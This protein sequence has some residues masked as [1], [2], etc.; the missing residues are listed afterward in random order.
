MRAP[1][2]KAP[3]L[4]PS[5][6]NTSNDDD[7]HSRLTLALDSLQLDAAFAELAGV[8]ATT[9]DDDFL[10]RATQMSTPSPLPTTASQPYFGGYN[11]GGRPPMPPTSYSRPPPSQPR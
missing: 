2:T 8:R 11:S 4:P 1:P 3:P 9:I 10:A 5:T 7:L 6:T